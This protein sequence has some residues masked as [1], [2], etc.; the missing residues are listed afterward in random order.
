MINGVRVS[1]SGRTQALARKAAEARAQ[2]VAPK[3]DKGTVEDLVAE[4][5]AIPA[6]RLNL[7]PTTR[8]QYAS[9]M[10]SRIVPALG[11]V[12]VARLT[13]EQVADVFPIAS[14]VKPSTQRSTYAALVRLLDYAVKAQRVGVNVARQ[15]DRPS[16]G[17]SRHREVSPDGVGK[18]LAK[19]S[20]D[21]LEVAAWLGFGCGLRRGEILGLRWVD[22]DLERGELSVVG[23]LTRSSAGLVWG[24]P[25]TEKGKRNVPV[26]PPV[27][28]AL[29]A[30]RK[31][32]AAERL[33]AG[34]A[35]EGVG[36]V[37]ANEVG[38]Y[39]EPRAMSR[40]WASWARRAGVS[41]R[42][43]HLGRHYAATTLLASGAASVADIAAQLGHDPAV[44]LNTYA[45]AVAAGQRAASDALGASLI[46]PTS[47]P[48]ASRA[49]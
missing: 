17:G 4:W 18:M 7:R 6:E 21:R 41:D 5:C 39:V 3:A 48:T 31:R 36:T 38:G 45:T 19:A 14:S 37:L 23:N 43:T 22:V 10:R 24:K 13:A 25:K 47:V 34:E 26:P 33:A 42:G 1:G 20:G 15:V 35:W 32:Q 8:D 49:E 2:L 27:V 28:E 44:L 29:K 12:K 16:A 30:H 40:A 46:V 9:L 11:G